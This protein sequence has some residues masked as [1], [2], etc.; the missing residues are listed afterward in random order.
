MKK[1]VTKINEAAKIRL[2][3]IEMY[4]TGNHSLQ[5]VGNKYGVDKTTIREWMRMYEEGGVERLKTYMKPRPTYHLDE[6]ELLAR[7]EAE[8][9]NEVIASL[10]DLARGMGLNDTAAKWGITPQGLAKRRR[11]YVAGQI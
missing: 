10:L 11:Q 2:A 3:A 9:D 8:P 5:E 4:Q 7:H 6:A 1:K